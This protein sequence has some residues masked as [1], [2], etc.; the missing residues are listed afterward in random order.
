MRYH[1]NAQVREE[2]GFLAE[3]MVQQVDSGHV[4]GQE[5]HG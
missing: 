5:Q 3:E 4:Q 1:L 2:L